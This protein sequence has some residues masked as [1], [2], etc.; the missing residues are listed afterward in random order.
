M[1]AIVK[2]E[3]VFIVMRHRKLAF[4]V[5]GHVEYSIYNILFKRDCFAIEKVIPEKYAMLD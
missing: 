5:T 3:Q 4:V 1:K 2:F